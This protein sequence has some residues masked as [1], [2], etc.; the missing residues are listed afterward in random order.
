MRELTK[1]F[2]D[3]TDG[4]E[5]MAAQVMTN[6]TAQ[7]VVKPFVHVPAKTEMERFGQNCHSTLLAAKESCGKGSKGTA[8]LIRRGLIAAAAQGPL[9]KEKVDTHNHLAI[10]IIVIVYCN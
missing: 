2:L 10:V 1:A 6:F 5:K 8:N 9:A 3:V 7:R 4:S